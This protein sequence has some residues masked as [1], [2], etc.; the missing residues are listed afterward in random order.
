[1]LLVLTNQAAYWVVTR[2]A[3]LA[4]ARAAAQGIDGGAGFSAYNNAYLLWAV[5]HGIVTV[6]LVT[7]LMPRMSRAAADDDPDAIRRDVSYALR[8][9]AAAIVPAACLL[10]ALAQPL[11]AVVFQYGRTDARDIATMAAILVAFAP[12]LVAFSGQYVLSR[13]FYALSDT[14][15]P[16]LL[17][18]VIAGLNAGLSLAAYATLPAR[19]AV[20]GMAGAYS[21]ALLAGWVVTALVLR[22]RLA[23]GAGTDGAGPTAA[24]GAGPTPAFGGG[25]TPAFGGG[26]G[27]ER[28]TGAPPVPPPGQPPGRHRAPAAR[29]RLWR[30]AAVGAHARL[31][32]AAVPAAALGHLAAARTMPVGAVAACAA[33]TVVVGLVFALLARPLRLTEL[34]RL[35]SGLTRRLTKRP[36]RR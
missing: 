13:A 23:R 36:A 16:F 19:W 4:G 27:A 29:A 9:S 32:A 34:D 35:L 7:A 2:L 6:S 8:S 10:L 1:M 15:T 33:G 30:S 14:R 31:L 3:T 20:T 26:A 21:V 5:P 25:P 12:G 28:G 17:N 11:M 18:L 24:D 22:R